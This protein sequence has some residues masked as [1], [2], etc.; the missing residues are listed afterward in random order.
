MKSYL[1]C[2][3]AIFVLVALAHAARIFSEGVHPL[4]QP[5]FVATSVVSIALA[6]WAWRIFRRLS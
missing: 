3:G 4:T 1:L 2:T 6:I 5:V